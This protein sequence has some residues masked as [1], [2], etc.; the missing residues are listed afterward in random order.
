LDSSG[1]PAKEVLKTMVMMNV[2]EITP[3][4]VDPVYIHTYGILA[5]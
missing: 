2:R 5:F 3:I 1:T 4:H